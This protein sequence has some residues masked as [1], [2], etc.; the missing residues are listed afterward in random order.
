MIFGSLGHLVSL[1]LASIPEGIVT[2][3]GP[4]NWPE[5]GAV[6]PEHQL[7][8]LQQ[9][10][11]RLFVDWAAIRNR[12]FFEDLSPPSNRRIQESVTFVTVLSITLVRGSIKFL[13]E[14]G[15]VSGR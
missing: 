5:A 4:V 15:C 1:T 2:L 12:A 11:R 8:F 9:A 3:L 10:A 6:L 13:A 14:V 7:S